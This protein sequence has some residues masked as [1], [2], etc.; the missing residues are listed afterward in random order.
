M[1]T[2]CLCVVSLSLLA[3]CGGQ[4]TTQNSPQDP[5]VIAW[6][7]GGTITEQDLDRAILARPA[8]QRQLPAEN[9][10]AWYETLVKELATDQLLL[11]E[12]ELIGLA[13]D[14]A[15][16]TIQRNIQRRFATERFLASH[17]PPPQPPSEKALRQYFEEH[18]DEYYRL[19]QRLV[20]HLFLQ[21]KSGVSEQ[22][23]QATAQQIRA[24]L[25]NGAAFSSLVEEYS[26][27]E[28]RHRKG[29][30]G[31]LKPE[32]VEP[33]VAKIVFG[34][35][36]GLPS[37][38]ITTQDGVHLFLVDNVIAEKHFSFAEVKQL[39]AQR[40]A[41]SQRQAAIEALLTTLAQPPDTFIPDR[42]TLHALSRAADPQA[43]V[44]R[45]GHFRLSLGQLQAQAAEAAEA[46]QAQLHNPQQTGAELALASAP[47]DQDPG[48]DLS[49]P[50]ANAWIA[51]R[52]GRPQ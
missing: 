46:A 25:L 36:M 4:Q 29:V 20:S 31:W 34:L 21:H 16:R 51:D 8:F 42:E 43:L 30:L 37:E 45:I 19:A 14:P 48:I 50:A 1:K 13:D 33:A 10:A 2:V 39:V 38:P 44:L 40:L 47:G 24:R 28:S 7:D 11:R 23:V 15:F 6:F 12:A 17:L 49:L 35:E 22:E 26:A 32:D 41:A 9:R 52:G 3:S 27:S 5:S 18:R